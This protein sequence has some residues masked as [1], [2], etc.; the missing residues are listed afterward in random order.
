VT[1]LGNAHRIWFDKKADKIITPAPQLSNLVKLLLKSS[2]DQVLP[3]GYP[4]NKQ[5]KP[6]ND[7]KFSNKILIIGGGAGSGRIEKQLEILRKDL[8]NK[9]II[10][11]C[12]FNKELYKKLLRVRDRNIQVYQFVDNI[13]NLMS[14]CDLIITKAGP[15]TIMEAAQMEKPVIITDWVGIQ[16]KENVNFVVENNLGIYCPNLNNLPSDVL[17][18]YENYPKYISSKNWNGL[19]DICAYLNKLLA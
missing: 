5:F 4:I 1:D 10:V 7:H 12:G 19:V 3:L 15:G 18:I 2:D 13:Y 6:K 14:D 8:S 17:R 9:K 11:I 16:E